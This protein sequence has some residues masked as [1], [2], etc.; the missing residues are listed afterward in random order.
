MSDDIVTRAA[1]LDEIGG[2]L[3]V[4]DLLLERTWAEARCGSASRRAASATATG[5]P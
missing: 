2:E 5:M 4:Q 1:V 3:V